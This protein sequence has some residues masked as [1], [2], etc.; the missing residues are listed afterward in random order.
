CGA[1]LEQDTD[2]LTRTLGIAATQAAGLKSQFGTMCKPLHAGK[3]SENGLFAAQMANRGFSSR[4][5]ILECAQG[6]GQT[7]GQ[8]EAAPSSLIKDD[9]NAHIRD[10]L[11]K[12]DAACYGTHA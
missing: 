4:S 11:F 12:F 6:F 5:D 2:T 9:G 8:G 7:L 10:T 3:A 1:L